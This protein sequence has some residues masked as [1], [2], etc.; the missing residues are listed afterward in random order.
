MPKSA[1]ERPAQTGAVLATG[2]KLLAL[3]QLHTRARESHQLTRSRRHPGEPLDASDERLH[4]RKHANAA[5][6]ARISA[7]LEGGGPYHQWWLQQPA[8]MEA[9]KAA[10]RP[11]VVARS[12][13][14]DPTPKRLAAHRLSEM[15]QPQVR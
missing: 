14:N 6:K 4:A 13:A 15:Q 12:E 1:R 5:R 8:S 3:H 2:C 7:S 9:A 11:A 10:R